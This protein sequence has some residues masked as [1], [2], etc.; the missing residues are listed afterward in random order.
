MKKG[1]PWLFV[2][3]IVTV[4]TTFAQSK[5]DL[6]SD[7]AKCIIAKDSVQKALTGLSATYD[8]LSKNYDSVSK[9]CLVYDTMYNVIRERIFKYAY[10]PSNMPA[11]LDSLAASRNSAFTFLS[12]TMSD[13][14]T[15]LNKKNADLKAV[16]ETLSTQEDQSAKVVSDL[17]QLKELLDS[18]IIT[19]TE[20]DAKKAILLEKL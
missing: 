16:I 6:E 12:T 5:K 11:L 9:T 8:V 1:L 7:Y 3:M 19:Q 2:I 17:K 10:K 15:V 14:I 18:G 13:S 20:F 4:T